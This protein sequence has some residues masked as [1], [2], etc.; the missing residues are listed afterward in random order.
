LTTLSDLWNKTTPEMIRLFEEM[1]RTLEGSATYSANSYDYYC[2]SNRS[3]IVQVYEQ[4]EKWF[5][6]YP[7]NQKVELKGRFRYEF[8]PA[9]FELY[10]YT[11]FTAMGYNLE[12][13]PA[14][15]NKST[16]PDYLAKKGEEKF[17]IE[18]KFIT[19]LSQDEQNAERKMNTVMDALNKVDSSNF[20]LDLEEITLKSDKQPSGKSIIRFFNRE[21][22]KINPDAYQLMRDETDIEDMD[23]II[24]DG[25]DIRIASRLVP[26]PAEIRGNQQGAIGSHP[27]E[28]TWGN[29][30]EN[31]KDALVSKASRYG[32]FDA[33]FII[34]I[35]KQTVSFDIM[36]LQQALY[37]ELSSRYDLNSPSKN[38]KLGFDGNGLF[39][40]KNN[41]KHTRVSGV[42][43][44]N[45]N[46]SNLASAEHAYRMNEF[47][48][49][50]L[51]L[52]LTQDIKEALNI[53]SD[54]PG[55]SLPDLSEV[56]ERINKALMG[57]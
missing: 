14:M 44:T 23:L 3:E 53:K 51:E 29:H 26:K 55:I 41:Q 45:A 42:Y 2:R 57:I 13:H 16:K 15:Q 33:P 11:L 20:W 34:C 21:I 12:V 10:I 1:E 39:G 7:E 49:Y 47:A 5:A 9:F 36:E 6:A 48:A 18:V 54:Y 56:A 4:L 43:F 19:L 17:Y 46:S 24:Y 35:N 8:Q 32:K 27:I 37:G 31:L 22:Q 40:N 25:D 30:S 52:K 38:E 28:V 50:P